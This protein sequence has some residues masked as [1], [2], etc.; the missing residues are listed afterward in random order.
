MNK[1]QTSK[2]REQELLEKVRDIEN[3]WKLLDGMVGQ[4]QITRNLHL[5]LFEKGISEEK[6]RW[7]KKI[8]ELK[9][10]LHK[11]ALN[12]DWNS[13]LDKINKLLGDAE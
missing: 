6:A 8:E 5:E 3:K 7:K 12:G 11:S 1:T 9:K 4:R 13:L 10:E 2:S